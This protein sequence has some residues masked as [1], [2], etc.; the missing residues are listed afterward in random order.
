[1]NRR[2]TDDQGFTL[3]E[4]MIALAILSLSLTVISES[5]VSSV[6]FVGHA[7]QM[8]IATMLARQLMVE[9]EDELFEEGFSDFE[10][11]K[12]GDFKE[13]GFETFRYVLKV[14]KVELPTEID[15]EGAADAVG[16]AGDGDDSTATGGVL[17]VGAKMMASQFEMFRNILEQSIR[18][19]TVRVLWGAKKHE[20]FISLVAYFTDPRK[21]DAA[22]PLGAGQLPAAGGGSLTNPAAPTPPGGGLAR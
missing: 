7:K 12:K 15:A 1:M 8:T 6:R 2:R 21:V 9:T 16:G 20:R 3:L 17:G 5:Q 11:E 13:Q 14:D 18:R 22:S 10:E 19:V 4:V